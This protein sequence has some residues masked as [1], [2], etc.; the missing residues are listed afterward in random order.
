[1]EE[2]SSKETPKNL[3]EEYGSIIMNGVR[4]PTSLRH[5]SRFELPLHEALSL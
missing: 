2:I 1:M 4:M 5:R 3:L